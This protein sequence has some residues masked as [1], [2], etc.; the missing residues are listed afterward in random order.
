MV[1]GRWRNLYLIGLLG[2]AACVS[3]GK[4][5]NPLR[6]SVTEPMSFEERETAEIDLISLI[7]PEE[8][9]FALPGRNC[10]LPRNMPRDKDKRRKIYVNEM[11]C[12]IAA[13]QTYYMT[14]PQFQ[15]YVSVADDSK[16]ANDEHF[17]RSVNSLALAIKR[18][19]IQDRIMLR[20]DALCLDF[21]RRLGLQVRVEND[22]TLNN[23]LYNSRAR[24]FGGVGSLFLD[25]DVIWA[26][27]NAT[28]ISGVP[29]YISDEDRIELKVLQIA[30]EG[31][32]LVRE[33]KFEDI[34]KRRF[35]RKAE[36]DPM[37]GP[38]IGQKFRPLMQPTGA[39]ITDGAP[40]GTSSTY[41]DV[42][43][44]IGV[45]SIG[46]YTLEQ[47]LTDVVEY[48]NYCSISSG[49]DRVTL[50]MEELIKNKR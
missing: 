16:T 13:F 38:R 6:S 17:K 5:S 14:W 35:Y 34:N 1:R 21:Q 25:S 28:R 18:N 2:L 32:T 37:H 39:D 7:D 45:V 12:A 3:D 20:S 48:H 27:T 4:P 40:P 41:K 9:R 42:Q 43:K 10:G 30:G 22:T 33:D 23:W 29:G 50:E 24:I 11:S 36:S 49:L 8:R 31:I 46:S 19:Q 47:A 44:T 15:Q 26:L